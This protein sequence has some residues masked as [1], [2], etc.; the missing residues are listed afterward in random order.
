MRRYKQVEEIA[1]LMWEPSQIRN[2]GIVAHVDHGKT[3]LTDSLV[4]A[5][6]IISFELA[7]DQLFTDYLDI[8]QQ[9]G[10]TVQ[11]AAV[12]LA[13][14]YEGKEYLINLLDTPG[15]VDFSGD[16]TRALRAIDGAVVV[17]DAVEGIM[18]QTE[19]VTRQALQERTKPVL[20]INKVDRLI[21]ELKLTPEEMQVRFAKLITKFNELIRRFAP[22]EVAE[23]WKI[24]V[25]D[26]S[27]AFGS[28]KEKWALSVPQMK[29]KNI[30]FKDIITAYQSENQIELAKQSPL[31]EVVL[32]MVIKHLPDP[33]T[34]QK[35]RIPVLWKGDLE[36]E[37]G[38]AMVNADPNGKL[39]MV[40]T[41]IVVDEQAGVISTGRVFS[42]T[43][44]KGKAVHLMNAKQDARIQQVSIYMGPDRVLVD[45]VPAGNIAA[46]IGMKEAV[47]GET[48]VEAGVEA[49]GF[50]ELR[51]ISEP[52]VTVAVEPKNFQELPKLIDKLKKIAKEDPN[53][54]VKIN[55]ETGEYLVSGM[56]E[57]HLEIVEYK[58]REAGLEVKT[59]EPIVVY[60]E[61]VTK[62]AGPIEGKSPNRHNR[63]M[64]LVEPLEAEVI[65]AIEEKKISN[66]QDRKERAAI[67]RE[68]GWETH[69][70]RNVVHILG[71]N[72]LVDMTKGVQFMKDVEDYI[73]EAFKNVV[74]EGPLMREPS[75]GLKVVIDDAMLH[76]DSVH[77]GPAQIIPAVRRPIQASILLGDPI[78]LEPILKLEVRVPQEF[79]GGATKVIQGRRGKI[80]DMQTEE[81]II[82]LKALLPVANSFGLAAELRSETQ[83]RA[84]WATEFAKFDK[85][86]PDLQ[87][88]IITNTR[89]RKG[90]KLEPPRPDEFMEK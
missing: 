52:V 11:T 63:F 56:G 40:V 53:I 36:S 29:K 2:I 76:E 54:Q 9:R 46:L 38:N 87:K 24:N 44:E 79:M 16:V 60:R 23:E 47:V 90:L 74:E 83:G 64:I 43:V 39:C 8:E 89:K 6:G 32:D 45:K 50:E 73:I 33:K 61:T 68:L 80:V 65:K 55:E 22:K 85:V 18:P 3:T 1:K 14:N 58:L 70:A 5:S 86:P 84:I 7:G 21:T 34:A 82:I 69:A 31:Y 35:R 62:R 88:Q 49:Q 25:E 57:V 17:M 19:T 81:D 42:G 10:I 41:D 75:R 13:H 66:D 72:V 20:F 77:R 48:I 59:S 12:S 4:A 51:Y 26:G 30:S 67:L 28:A 37:L 27:V 71:P 78:V 15:H